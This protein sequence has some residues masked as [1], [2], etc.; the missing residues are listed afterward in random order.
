[1]DL[2]YV[3]E[4]ILWVTKQKYRVKELTISIWKM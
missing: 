2:D 3:I 4:T 1:M